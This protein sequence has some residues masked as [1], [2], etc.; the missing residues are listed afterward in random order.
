M[1]SDTVS[2]IQG[3]PVGNT[4]SL[5]RSENLGGFYACD[6]HFLTAVYK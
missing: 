1:V 3:V 5:P 2:D 4:S 6:L